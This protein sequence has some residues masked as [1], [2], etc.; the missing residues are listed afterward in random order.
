V[1]RG[2]DAVTSGIDAV[3]S[4]IDAVTSGIGDTIR[5]IGD[6]SIG[7]GRANRAV[8]NA[9]KWRD[10]VEVGALQV[11]MGE[12][13]RGVA[14]HSTNPLEGVADHLG[15]RGARPLFAPETPARKALRLVAEVRCVESPLEVRNL[16]TRFDALE[17]RRQR[18]RL[19]VEAFE[20]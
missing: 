10:D 6:A 3:T 9:K 15:L 19:G 1:K 13:L 18:A 16:V 14:D 17:S 7:T 20:F 8:D 2:I 5:G 11:P 4:G 12:P